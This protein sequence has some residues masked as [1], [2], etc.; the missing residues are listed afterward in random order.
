MLYGSH[1]LARARVF[2][3]FVLIITYGV[4]IPN[5]WRRSAAV[6][7]TLSVVAL[8]IQTLGGAWQGVLAQ[9]PFLIYLFEMAIWLGFATG[10]VVFNAYR[11]DVLG[12]ATATARQL[13]QYRLGRRLGAGGMGEVYLAEHVLL[14]RPCA[15]KLIR[16]E[17]AGDPE[18]LARFEREVRA[19]AALTHPN[20]VQVFDYGRGRRRHV[21]LRDGVPARPDPG[22]ARRG[23]RPA[24]ARRGPSTCCG[25]SAARSRGARRRA[26]P[27][28]HQAGQRHRLRARRAWP[29]WPSC[30]TSAWC[31]A[32]AGQADDAS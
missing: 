8:G 1:D 26:D 18:N 31:R 32:T 24:A 5:S 6:L 15:V 21:L 13:G 17:R 9:P 2:P 7:S 29:T 16:P 25:R 22:P 28:R 23:A 20:T 4:L 3:W 14:R 12:A 19:T 27:P 10:V 11:I 30:S